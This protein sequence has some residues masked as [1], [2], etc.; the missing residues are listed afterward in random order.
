MYIFSLFN[1]LA[2][3][4]TFIELCR[5]SVRTNITV[6]KDI[7]KFIS[8]NFKTLNGLKLR[9]EREREREKERL[10]GKEMVKRRVH[11]YK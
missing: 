1:N 2:H 3:D 5:G 6:C 8:H 4:R 7:I 10:F 9:R 11:N